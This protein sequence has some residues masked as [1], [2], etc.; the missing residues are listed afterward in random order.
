MDS[1]IIYLNKCHA[2][3][4]SSDET[5]LEYKI[6][7]AKTK[8]CIY[9]KILIAPDVCLLK[10]GGKSKNMTSKKDTIASPSSQ[11]KVG[12]HHHHIRNS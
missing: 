11:E 3:F 10:T 7:S 2:I 12:V 1:S 9:K 8:N 4:S 5:F 6:S